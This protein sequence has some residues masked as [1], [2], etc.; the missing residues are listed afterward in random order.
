MPHVTVPMYHYGCC[1]I[2]AVRHYAP[3]LQGMDLSI[4]MDALAVIMYHAACMP[5]MP[6]DVMF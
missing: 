6:V 4:L 2:L 5:Y 1:I 3:Y